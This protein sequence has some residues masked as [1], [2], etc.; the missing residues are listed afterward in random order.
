M[1]N[2]A[3]HTGAGRWPSALADSSDFG[4]LGE[5]SSPKICDFLP[6]TPINRQENLTP[7]ALSSA[8]KP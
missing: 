6:W 4:L 5:Q 2:D 7:L 8:K 1:A 3:R